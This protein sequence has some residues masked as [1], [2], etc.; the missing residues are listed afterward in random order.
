[1]RRVASIVSLLDSPDVATEKNRCHF[2]QPPILYLNN[3]GNS[4]ADDIRAHRPCRRAPAARPTDESA[5]SALSLA[6]FLLG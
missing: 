1:M 6:C 5:A 4:G 3:A 2:D